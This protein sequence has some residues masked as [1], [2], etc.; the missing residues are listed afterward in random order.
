MIVSDSLEHESTYSPSP[1][2]NSYMIFILSTLFPFSYSIRERVRLAIFNQLPW[3]RENFFETTV[4][5]D[6]DPSEFYSE[7]RRGLTRHVGY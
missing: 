2:N 5:Y 3:G 4:T 1:N 6:C 7:Q